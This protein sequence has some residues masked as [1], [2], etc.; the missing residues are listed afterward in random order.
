M[1]HVFA[2]DN[3]RTLIVSD[4][5]FGQGD[6]CIAYKC[7]IKFPDG[8]I[9]PGILKE[10]APYKYNVSK[11]PGSENE[12]FRY[13]PAEKEQDK[14]LD[15]FNKYIKRVNEKNKI[16]ND[17]IQNS[18]DVSLSWYYDVN[19]THSP[20]EDQLIEFNESN[21]T[22]RALFLTSY[23]SE[24]ASKSLGD[25]N[26]VGRLDELIALCYVVE[27]FHSHNL[28]LADLKPDNY[29]FATDGD[30]KQIKIIDIDSMLQLDE[31]GNICDNQDI[32]GTRFYSFHK[33][34]DRIIKTKFDSNGKIVKECSYIDK[35]FLFKNGEAKKAD[36]YSIGALLLNAVTLPI[37]NEVAT[38]KKWFTTEC[39]DAAE[40]LDNC[41]FEK[42][43]NYGENINIGFWN[44][45]L[46][47]ISQSVVHEDFHI[48]YNSVAEIKND[49]IVLKEI[50]LGK[51]VHPEVMLNNAIIDVK[52]SKQFS[53]KN[54]DPDLFTD[55]EVV[56]D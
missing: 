52:N 44:K 41:Y 53:E 55:I 26:L 5:P 14:F 27:K 2:F 31:Y 13:L 16:L 45:F 36:I 38:E 40:D 8:S 20:K 30:I 50:L 24:D 6:N 18:K 1:P 56:N 3:K 46:Q 47:I 11:V 32:T 22:Y 48:T 12:M 37:F 35:D 7:D 29:I 15:K 51:G 23:L 54:F 4:T 34:V 42:L 49:I 9:L 43:K 33:I 21:H 28:L 10:F 25:L 17:I 39:I 19:G